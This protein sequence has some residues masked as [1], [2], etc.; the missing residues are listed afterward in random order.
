MH[1]ALRAFRHPNYVRYFAGQSV[2][3]LGTWIQ[4]I[5]L[6]WLVYRLSGSAFLL[7]L[8]GF[9]AQIALL[10]FAPFGVVRPMQ[11]AMFG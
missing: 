11:P 10:I 9:A 8:T 3:I 6:S 5:A 7:G 1:H 2:S 4:T